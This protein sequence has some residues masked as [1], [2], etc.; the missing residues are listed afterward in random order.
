VL[1]CLT[2]VVCLLRFSIGRSVVFG[3][4]GLTLVRRLAMP[5]ALLELG[6]LAGRVFSFL[7]DLTAR[8]LAGP[9]RVLMRVVLSELILPAE[10]EDG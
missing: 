3:V 4:D 10:F 5:A 2:K 8:C 9:I 1:D 7:A 6:V